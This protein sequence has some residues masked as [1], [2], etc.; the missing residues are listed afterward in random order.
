MADKRRF[1]YAVCVTVFDVDDP[2]NVKL[3]RTAQTLGEVEVEVEP[4]LLKRGDE[5]LRAAA[6][7]ASERAHAGRLM[8]KVFD[9]GC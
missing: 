6:A 3:R 7:Q 8:G 4:D 5:A 1:G 9:D 2:S